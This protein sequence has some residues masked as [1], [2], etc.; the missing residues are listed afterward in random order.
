MNKITGTLAQL[1]GKVSVNGHLRTAPQLSALT[2]M[3]IG[4]KVGEAA[5]EPNTRGRAATIWEFPESVVL[6]FESVEATDG[7]NN[8]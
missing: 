5:K 4:T 2:A 3:G 8:S 6:N 1:S 7:G